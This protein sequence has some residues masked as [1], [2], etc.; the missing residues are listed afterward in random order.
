MIAGMSDWTADEGRI[1]RQ[2]GVRHTPPADIA[3]SSQPILDWIKAESIAHLAVHWDLDVLDAAHFSP[4]LFNQPDQPEGTFDGIV[5]GTMRLGQVVRLL[6]D[7]SAACDMVGL[8]IAEF[9]PRGHAA[10][11]ECP[12]RGA[13]HAALL[14]ASSSALLINSISP[15]GLI[16]QSH[17][18]SWVSMTASG[19]FETLLAAASRRSTTD[20][21][22]VMKARAIAPSAHAISATGIRRRVAPCGPYGSES[23]RQPRPPDR[24]IELTG[25]GPRGPRIGRSRKAAFLG[26]IGRSEILAVPMG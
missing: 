20:A 13:H 2:L 1:L 22:P 17:K 19:R 4:L 16:C 14:S 24:R 15:I 21:S 8:A 5:Q 3:D 25:D 26:E 12:G 10:R 11:Q 6:Q 9:L 7:V 18:L 23:G